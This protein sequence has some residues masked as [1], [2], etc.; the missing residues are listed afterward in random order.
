MLTIHNLFKQRILTIMQ[1]FI[2][3]VKVS[4]T[5][6]HKEAEKQSALRA[7]IE[8]ELNESRDIANAERD[9]IANLM[10][11]SLAENGLEMLT[12][13]QTAKMIYDIGWWNG[14]GVNGFNEALLK[15]INLES[16]NVGLWLHTK[17][18]EGI[19]VFQLIVPESATLQELKEIQS[20]IEPI[21]KTQ[22]ELFSEMYIEVTQNQLNRGEYYEEYSTFIIGFNSETNEYE[23]GELISKYKDFKSNSFLE[24]LKY[25]KENLSYDLSK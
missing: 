7:T 1:D 25:V 10:K 2:E 17:N 18:N 14:S 23:V 21:F 6:I 5:K 19:K 3:S 8:D 15:A 20:K 22:L 16:V 9:N 12:N 4:R 13:I 11:K 24:I